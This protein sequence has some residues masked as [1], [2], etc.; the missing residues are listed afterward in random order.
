[1]YKTPLRAALLGTSVSLLFGCTDILTSSKLDNRPTGSGNTI[2]TYSMPKGL[3]VIEA[4]TPDEATSDP[5][6]RAATDKSAK[7][8][9]KG[10]T[11]PAS[12]SKL[13]YRASVQ[14]VPDT[15]EQFR[16]DYESSWFAADA[17][18]LTTRNGLLNS[19]A[20]TSDDRTHEA[21]VNLARSLGAARGFSLPVASGGALAG[22]DQETCAPKTSFK[23]VLD[24]NNSNDLE[25]LP[26]WLELNYM[27]GKG[28]QPPVAA[29]SATDYQKA[30]AAC[31]QGICTRAS[32]PLRIRINKQCTGGQAWQDTIVYVPDETQF[33]PVR[34]DRA[35]FADKCFGV[36]FTDGMVSEVRIRNAS[37]AE[38]LASMPEDILRA[39]V[40]IPSELLQLRFNY[41]VAQRDLSAAELSRLQAERALQDYTKG[42]T[43]SPGSDASHASTITSGPLRTIADAPTLT[44]AECAV[45]SK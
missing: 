17:L 25:N 27:D 26:G 8:A 23:L 32:R 42:A 30:V 41:S 10:A 40:T 43:T 22:G 37:T 35:L 6:E 13:T 11:P 45:D 31:E 9:T 5:S 1:M 18:K 14:I 3:L 20:A 15:K 12:G 24:L 33:T 44:E 38:N 34:L 7:P 2:T 21:V 39:L 29:L 36:G 4:T 16:V 28:G 19:V